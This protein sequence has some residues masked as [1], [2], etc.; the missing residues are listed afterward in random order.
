M[1]VMTILA[2]ICFAVAFALST[3]VSA[4]TERN[5]PAGTAGAP[6]QG[7]TMAPPATAAPPSTGPTRPVRAPGGVNVAPL[8][9]NDC[10][11]LGGTVKDG[12]TACLS[13]KA[14]QTTGEDKQVHAVCISKQ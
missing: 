2:A 11:N 3:S 7:G 10:S 6:V 9:A 4:Q 14:C 12:V 5:R 8:T 13:G 1:R